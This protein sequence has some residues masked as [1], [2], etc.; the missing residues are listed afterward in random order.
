MKGEGKCLSETLENGLI[1]W[2]GIQLCCV[3]SHGIYICDIRYE[4]IL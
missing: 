3:F 2:C 4:G 1:T